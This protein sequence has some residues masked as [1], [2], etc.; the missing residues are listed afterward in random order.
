MTGESAAERRAQFAKLYARDRIDNQIDY[1]HRRRVEA[2]R[3]HDQAIHGKWA[4][5]TLAAVAGSVGAALPAVR[6]ELAI[7]AAFL[8]AAA[9]ALTAYQSL[10]AFPRLAKLYG[11]AEISLSALNA[12]GKALS[13]DLTPEETRK[14][15]GRIEKVFRQE[16]SQWGQLIQHA[17]G[18]AGHHDGAK[19]GS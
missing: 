13:S 4:L 2:Q 7:A 11:D 19:G 6:I 8:A 17:D 5:S 10:Y 16:N 1:Y 18:K 12:A 3:A 15:V 14:L 9:T